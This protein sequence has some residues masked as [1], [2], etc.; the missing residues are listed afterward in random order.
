MT[1]G[2]KPLS[3]CCF[4][5]QVSDAPSK[6]ANAERVKEWRRTTKL[7]SLI[8]SMTNINTVRFTL[9]KLNKAALATRALADKSA[10]A[11]D[12]AQV[13]QQIAQEPQIEPATAAAVV[14]APPVVNDVAAAAAAVAPPLTDDVVGG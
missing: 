12:G 6:K 7:K 2:P 14:V 3:L 10:S 4:P 8:K 11:D 5:L 1:V 13:L 9:A